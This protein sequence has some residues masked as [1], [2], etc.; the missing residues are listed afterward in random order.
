MAGE[1]VTRN[2]YGYDD[3][4]TA[5]GTQP[6]GV[7]PAGPKPPSVFEQAGTLQST[8]ATAGANAE[9]AG[10]DEAIAQLMGLLTG[11]VSGLQQSGTAAGLSSTLDEIMAGDQFGGLVDER[12]RNAT[13]A[14]SSVGLSRSGALVD[15]AVGI[16]AELA[17][18]L[19]NQ[20]YGRNAATAGM[21]TDIS[22]MIAQL[23]GQSGA[24]TAGGI[25][26]SAEAEAGGI[27]G[28]QGYL[29][30][31]QQ[32]QDQNQ[33][34]ALGLIGTGIGYSVGGPVGGAI[35]GGIGGL[36]S[37]PRL[38]ENIRVEGKIGPLDLVRWDW[39]PEVP[40]IV[41]RCKTIG[42]MSPQVK[43]HYPDLVSEYG[44]FDVINYKGLMERLNG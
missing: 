42:F 10:L 43:E 29:L 17:L 26:G 40:E 39:I 34:D 11:S 24:A 37:D 16:P 20:L 1:R 9:V 23:L 5:G 3:T 28:E 38:K 19:E 7:A 8:A 6:F 4:G 32:Q 15:S 2:Q 18:E 30:S 22:R 36:F 33:N 31:Q 14:L 41:S 21:E 12:T 44:G 27:L 25:T 35:G 13:G